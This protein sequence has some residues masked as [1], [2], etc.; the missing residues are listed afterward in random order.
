MADV[1][2]SQTINGAVVYVEGMG[3][4]GTTSEVELPAI[5][6]ETFEW[7]GGVYRRGII[8]LMLNAWTNKL[9]FRDRSQDHSEI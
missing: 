7:N 5:E 2:K 1:R 6:F 4:V 9:K 8:T 3:F